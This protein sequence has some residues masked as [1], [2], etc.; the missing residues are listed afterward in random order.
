MRGDN[1]PD[2]FYPDVHLA[3]YRDGNPIPGCIEVWKALGVALKKRREAIARLDKRGLKA[4][5]KYIK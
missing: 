5:I 3:D 4:S 1:F 2:V